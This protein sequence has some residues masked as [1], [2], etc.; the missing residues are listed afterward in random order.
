MVVDIMGLIPLR[1]NFQELR[2]RFLLTLNKKGSRS[3]SSLQAFTLIIHLNIYLFIFLGGGV[4]WILVVIN[5][6]AFTFSYLGF[7]SDFSEFFF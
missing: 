6:N 2:N 4:K 7:Y 1:L 5:I 3:S